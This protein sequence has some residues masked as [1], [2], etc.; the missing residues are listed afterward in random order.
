MTIRIRDLTAVD[1]VELA[2]LHVATFTE[3]HSPL[4]GGP[5]LPLRIQQWQQ[6][7]DTG[8]NDWFAVGVQGP[9]GALIGFAKGCPHDGGISGY[10][11]ELSKLYLLRHFQGRGLGKRL[12]A[13]TAHR[14]LDRKIHSMLLF[15]NAR[16]SANGFYE[17]LGGSRL[18]AAN[19][20]FHGA[21]GWTDLDALIARCSSPAA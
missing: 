14:F 8:A 17:A 21:Y 4:G 20:E 10:A 13:E 11:G 9:D 18:Y 3:T 7:F 12:V 2:A 1:V 19:G 6:A 16:S 5:S 15:G